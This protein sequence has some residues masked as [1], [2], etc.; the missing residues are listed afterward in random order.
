MR[1]EGEHVGSPQRVRHK[2]LTRM[3]E[4]GT[5]IYLVDEHDGGCAYVDSEK[6]AA[7]FEAA[8]FVR[9]DYAHYKEA[10]DRFWAG[11]SRRHDAIKQ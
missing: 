6:A 1:D 5:R 2:G 3:A 8:G 9:T 7:E 4:S 11:D 10:H